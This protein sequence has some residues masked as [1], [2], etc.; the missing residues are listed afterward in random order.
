MPQTATKYFG[1]I[2]YQEA[3]AVQFP[4][5]LPAFEDE[6]QFLI[7]ESPASAPFVFLQSLR[8]PSLCFLA[9]PV[10]VV[11]PEYQLALSDED[12]HT[13]GLEP[14][15]QPRIGDEVACLAVIVAPENRPITANL[16]AP[17]VINTRGRR[18]VQAIRSDSIYSHKHAVVVRKEDVCS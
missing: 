2:E 18:G 7:L 3:D 14:G 13:L 4:C 12:L 6:S 11:D 17:I 5:G 1:S 15:R 10:P 9:L 16:L 8:L